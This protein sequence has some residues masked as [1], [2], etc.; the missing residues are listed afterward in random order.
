[1]R[2]LNVQKTSNKELSKKWNMD[3]FLMGEL[4]IRSDRN[5][6][7][8]WDKASVY[9]WAEIQDEM[10]HRRVHFTVNTKIHEEG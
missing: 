5:G 10:R 4:F 8:N 3:V 1:M 2:T 9:T 7:V 6:N